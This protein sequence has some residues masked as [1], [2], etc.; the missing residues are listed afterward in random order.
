MR[1]RPY[2]LEAKREAY[3][4]IR[5]H[6]SA[7]VCMPTGTGKG[8]TIGAIVADAVRA[9]K[10]VLVFVHRKEIVEQLAD[11]VERWSGIRPAIE[12]AERSECR[13]DSRVVVASVQTL[14]ARLDRFDPGRFDVLI[15]DEA[16]HG[17]ASQPRRIFGHFRNAKILGFTATPNRGDERALGQVFDAVAYDMTAAD[18]ILGGWLVP[19]ETTTIRLEALDLSAVRKRSGD[20]AVGELGAAMSMIEV[21]REAIEPAVDLAWDRKAIVFCCTVAHMHAVASTVRLVAQERR[22]PVAVAT[23]DGSTPRDERARIFADF[24]AGTIN[25]LCNV[26]IATEGVDIPTADA[27]I[28]LRPTLSRAL[29]VQMRGRGGRPLPGVVDGVTAADMA[30]R[31]DELM[32]RGEIMDPDPWTQRAIL[33]V[34]RG[35]D[36]CAR[37]LAIALSAKPSCMVLDFTDNSRHDLTSEMD[38]LGGEY[39]L[40][41]QR[42]AERMLQAGTTKNMIDAL[43]RA[44]EA[45]AAK[46]RERQARAGD[47]FALFDLPTRRDRY[48]REP[49]GKHRRLLA[50]LNLPRPDLDWREANDLAAEIARRD[51]AGLCSYQQAALLARAG[52]PIEP[53][54]EMGRREA[55]GR[56]RELA[57]VGWMALRK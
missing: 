31:L 25:W 13:P 51:A 14:A 56:V 57:S 17:L 23:V 52:H 18:A 12:L 19:F 6:R 27:V 49:T 44:R 3:R 1:L 8:A 34:H 46:M 33:G 22:R 54:A 38:L 32:V 11:H 41:V 20:L 7:L 15:Y 10:R 29:F 21:L 9:G 36:A 30:V 42:E 45:A 4:A 43:E 16:H 39:D 24:R 50:G 2:Q 37:R 40:P 26:G 28:M 47:P 35:D 48:G 55:A 53:L 5:K